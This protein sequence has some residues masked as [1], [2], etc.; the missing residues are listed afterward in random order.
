MASNHVI[1]ARTDP[2]TARAYWTMS[3]GD[4]ARAFEAAR[5]HSRL[6]RVLRVAI[7]VLIGFIA[8]AFLL[9]TFLNPLRMLTKLPINVGDLI[10][11][12]TKITMERP[13][14]AGFT[15]DSRAYEV[16]ADAA[17]QDL[18]KPDLVELKNINAKVELQDKTTVHLSAITGVYDSKAETL[19]LDRDIQLSSSSGYA[20]HLSEALVDIRKG[21]VVSN[22]PVQVKLLQGTLDANR[23]EIVDSGD[24]VRFD[25]GVSM[26]LMLNE[27]S[28]VKGQGA[29]A[30]EQVKAGAQ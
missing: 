27:A 20:G 21:N 8:L 19:K 29:A 1:T 3:R 6:V 24:V 22:K 16:S 13:H 18:T 4:A 26:I 23:L 12:G 28:T 14:L 25:G 30:P 15:S 11:S 7:P 9:V 10:V 2:Q 5:K 17:A